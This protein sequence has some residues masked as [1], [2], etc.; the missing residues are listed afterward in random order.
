MKKVLALLLAVICLCS[1]F[2]CGSKDMTTMA[3]EF[4]QAEGVRAT[5][6]IKMVIAEEDEDAGLNEQVI[7]SSSDL[8]LEPDS[9]N[10]KTN[11]LIVQL[12]APLTFD[13]Y[14]NA[15][16]PEGDTVDLT[17][18]KSDVE[19][20]SFSALT[21]K[22]KYFSTYSMTTNRFIASVDKPDEFFG[23]DMPTD[24]VEFEVQRGPYGPRKIEISYTTVS[25]YSVEIKIEYKYEG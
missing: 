11:Y 6:S 19:R 16:I 21:F 20:I 1:L 8:Y 5:A 17:A 25:G 24:E 12:F 22:T 3:T 15:I 7:T 23:I 18:S 9:K 10:G 4:A 2:S 13:D 14:G